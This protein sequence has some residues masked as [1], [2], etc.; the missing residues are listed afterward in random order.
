[1]GFETIAER[2]APPVDSLATSWTGSR[3]FS[4]ATDPVA[5]MTAIS[6]SDCRAVAR[7]LAVRFD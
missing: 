2:Q 3:R 4:G 1:M 6:R 5:I 7:S